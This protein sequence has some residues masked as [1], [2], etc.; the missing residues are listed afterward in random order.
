MSLRE[1]IGSSPGAG[2]LALYP[3]GL[4]VT[5]DGRA[6]KR[7]TKQHVTQNGPFVDLGVVCQRSRTACSDGLMAGINEVRLEQ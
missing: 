7:D 3:G 5:V 4:L 2:G 1:T 6:H